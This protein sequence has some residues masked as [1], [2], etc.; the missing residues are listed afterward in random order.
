MRSLGSSGIVAGVVL[1]VAAAVAVPLLLTAG[2]DGD[3]PQ[4]AAGVLA[5]G[6]L[7][8]G[9]A[10]RHGYVADRELR[11]GAEK[12][13]FALPPG[14][15]VRDLVALADGYLVTTGDQ[16]G[17]GMAY[18]LTADGTASG[19]WFFM[20]DLDIG[21]PVASADRRLAAVVAGGK[22]VVLQ[23]GGLATELAVP[24]SELGLP[25]SAVAVS[26]T[27]CRGADA[28]CT[29]LVNRM[30]PVG[31]GGGPGSTWSVRPGRAPVE[32]DRGIDDVKA[33]A[34]NGLTAGTVKIIED[35]DGSCAGVADPQGAV[36]WT[37]CQ[38][39]LLSFSPG[40]RSVLAG[41][42][43]S[44]GSGDHELTVLDASTGEQRLRLETAANVGIFEVAW[45]DDDHLLAV[46][47]DW[48]EDE[49]TGDHRDHR[50]A[51]LRVG[52]DGTREYAVEPVPGDP[53]DYDGPLDLP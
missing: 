36:L 42:S 10:P 40:S 20:P 14:G 41:T 28:D 11:R 52:L 22:A 37:T 17:E 39:R 8:T 4:A 26:G 13:S 44:F 50:W 24:V 29:V 19:K 15:D 3:S 30:E 46:V 47:A 18:A 23:E 6:D 34:D 5:L 33:V 45:E 31:D 9:A 2:D 25:V 27:D 16:D 35:G 49:Q 21:G 7:P 32:A 38:D 53:E 48:R 43:A 51:V 1:G 12:V